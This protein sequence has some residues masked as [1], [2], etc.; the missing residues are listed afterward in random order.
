MNDILERVHEGMVV[1]DNHNERVGKVE[2]VRMGDEDAAQL[3][4]ETAT[5]S[6]DPMINPLEETLAEV[7]NPDDLPQPVRDRLLRYGF[8]RIDKGLFRHD[9][10]VASDQIARIDGD[11]VVLKISADEVAKPVAD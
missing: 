6:R 2:F 7:F 11:Q 1:V 8:I 9:R 4:T 5:P 10:F 3:G